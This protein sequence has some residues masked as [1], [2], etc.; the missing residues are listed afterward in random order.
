MTEKDNSKFKE[1]IYADILNC[2]YCVQTYMERKNGCPL[3]NL[4]LKV[5]KH[6]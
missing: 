5:R 4:F 6:H 3:K 1:Q 2:E